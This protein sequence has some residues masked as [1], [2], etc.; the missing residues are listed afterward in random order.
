MESFVYCWTD[1]KTQMLY[2]GSH[3]GSA[4]DGYVCSSK[5]MI[6]Q[7]Y[8]RPNDFTRQILADGTLKDCR[9]LEHIILNTVDA[10]HDR[11]FYNQ[12]NGNAK[13]YCK[14]HTQKTKEKIRNSYTKDRKKLY[15]E[16]RMGNKNSFY[17][18]THSDETKT[19]WSIKKKGTQL[20][21]LNPSYGKYW[22]DGQK[23][24]MSIKKRHIW[25]FKTST[26]IVIIYNLIEFCQKNN[27][28]TC[29]MRRVASDKCKN[30]KGYSRVHE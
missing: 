14:A 22:S 19:L 2:V 24:S 6:E 27:L 26:G 12:C 30:H 16:S 7:Y 10:M 15:S 17:G 25:R 13:F 4:D 21:K 20:G 23:E 29:M 28:N 1:H 9:N 3:K 11:Q 18:K 5:T 8:N